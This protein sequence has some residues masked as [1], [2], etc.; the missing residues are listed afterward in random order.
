MMI[1]LIT[2]ILIMCFVIVFLTVD[3]YR[4]KKLFN[5][6]IDTLEEII[7]LISKKQ[8]EQSE[9]LRLSDDLNENLKRSRAALSSDIFNLNYELFSILDKHNILQKDDR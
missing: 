6:R 9:K 5:R 7:V 2:I 3:Q 8:M 1:I 4:K